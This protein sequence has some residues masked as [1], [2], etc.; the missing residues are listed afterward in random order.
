MLTSPEVLVATDVAARGQLSCAVIAKKRKT[1]QEE[2]ND[3]TA[4]VHVDPLCLSTS[5]ER[6]RQWSRPRKVDWREGVN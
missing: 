3:T 4:I 6:A 2:K 5:W 1:L